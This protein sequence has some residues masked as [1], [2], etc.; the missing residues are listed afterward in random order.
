MRKLVLL[1]LLSFIISSIGFNSF[2]SRSDVVTSMFTNID[3]FTSNIQ[4]DDNNVAYVQTSVIARN[5]DKIVIEMVLQRFENGTWKTAKSWIHTTFG[6]E[7]FSSNSV[8]V[9]K[10]YKYRLLSNVSVYKGNNLI[11][12]T[13]NCI[14]S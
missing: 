9:V 2:A 12:K 7:A 4:I 3:Y 6:T 10:E 14:D 1:V 5:V 11:E 13:N 8:V